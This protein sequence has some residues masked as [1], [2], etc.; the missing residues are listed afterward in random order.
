MNYTQLALS[1]FG[2]LVMIQ[3]SVKRGRLIRGRL[4]AMPWIEALVALILAGAVFYFT[5]RAFRGDAVVM[6]ALLVS[7]ISVVFSSIGAYY[8]YKR[9]VE[10]EG[11]GV[12]GTVAE[13]LLNLQKVACCGQFLFICPLV[14]LAAQMIFKTN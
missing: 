11:S 9:A 6:T 1:V 5:L 3:C 2:L 4:H 8:R 12:D 10:T 7:G 14:F 13:R